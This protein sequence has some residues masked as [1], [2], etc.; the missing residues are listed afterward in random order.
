MEMFVDGVVRRAPMWLRTTERGDS[1]EPDPILY[2]LVI[3]VDPVGIGPQSS[4]EFE[5]L[6]KRLKLSA[7]VMSLM[8]QYVDGT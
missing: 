5:V 6:G 7:T 8:K 4:I 2:S 1:Q 3:I